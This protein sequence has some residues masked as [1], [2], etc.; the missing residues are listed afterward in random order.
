MAL[1]AGYRWHHFTRADGTKGKVPR[2]IK[3]AKSGAK[4]KAK[5]SPKK[6]STAKKGGRSLEG[7]VKALEG[8]QTKIVKVLGAVVSKVKEHDRK[9]NALAGLA[10][11]MSRRQLGG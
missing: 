7:R 10:A 11:G 2:K 4:K 9:I 6:K 8:N 3:G 1:P 5:K